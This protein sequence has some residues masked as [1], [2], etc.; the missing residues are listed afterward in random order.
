MI[1]LR[2]GYLFRTKCLKLWPVTS[3]VSE[4]AEKGG[5]WE[6]TELVQCFSIRNSFIIK[7][8]E[9]KRGLWFHHAR[10]QTQVSASFSLQ[11]LAR[12][13]EQNER[14]LRGRS[15]LAVIRKHPHPFCG[16]PAKGKDTSL[17]PS[18]FCSPDGSRRRLQPGATGGVSPLPAQTHRGGGGGCWHGLGAWPRDTQDEVS[19]VL[20]HPVQLQS[21]EF[22]LKSMGWTA[23]FWH[24]NNPSSFV[25][26]H[27]W[28]SSI[29]RHPNQL[30]QMWFSLSLSPHYH[31]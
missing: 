28:F 1:L 25:R 30:F 14:S 21:P 10:C 5:A 31:N 6:G 18:P 22:P 13:G 26:T 16:F 8:S 4:G 24:K 2:T 3:S 17:L 29:L 23:T 11:R 9:G 12:P 27:I 15:I 7:I 20:H 19:E